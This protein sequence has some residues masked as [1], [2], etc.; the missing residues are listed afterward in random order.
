MSLNGRHPVVPSK[1]RAPHLAG[2]RRRGRDH[3]DCASRG[4]QPVPPRR[5]AGRVRGS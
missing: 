5:G 3:R 1:R 4:R 2:G